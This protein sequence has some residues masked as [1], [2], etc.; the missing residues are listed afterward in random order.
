[1][2]ASSKIKKIF[3]DW[4]KNGDGLIDCNEF[5]AALSAIGSNADANKLIA[6]MEEEN[7]KGGVMD[8]A[9]AD[10]K[11]SYKE[12][13]DWLKLDAAKVVK[14]ST[15]IPIWDKLAGQ[16]LEESG[17]GYERLGK[18]RLNPMEMTVNFAEE[19]ALLK[20]L[21][22]D[23]GFSNEEAKKSVSD[24]RSMNMETN[25]KIQYKDFL[26]VL[27]MNPAIDYID[28]KETCG[29]T[30]AQLCEGE[31]MSMADIM[32]FNQAE[33]DANFMIKGW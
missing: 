9:G 6:L 31:V 12:F 13:I 8:A 33:T 10:K 21:V 11:F 3:E 32:N 15:M 20:A 16:D 7:G 27:K 19:A 18:G 2:F 25:G 5:N 4:D 28:D 22:N 29:K 23:F 26:K 24:M 14:F 1:M 30:V 17:Q